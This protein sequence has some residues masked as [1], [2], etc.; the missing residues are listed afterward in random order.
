MTY[1]KYKAEKP[2]VHIFACHAGNTVISALTNWRLGLCN[3]YGLWHEQVCLNKFLLKTY[4]LRSR[5]LERY[6]CR[7]ILPRVNLQK[8][9]TSHQLCPLCHTIDESNQHSMKNYFFFIGSPYALWL[10]S[11]AFFSISIT[12]TARLTY[13]R[14]F[15]CF[16][17]SKVSA[18]IE[19][20]LAQND[21]YV[22]WHK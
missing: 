15:G 19:I 18:T 2:S 7:Y 10:W 6:C 14:V 1:L 22:S 16:D 8:V 13:S 11:Y 21:S 17:N 4:L 3:S 12:W 9:V 5:T 20:K